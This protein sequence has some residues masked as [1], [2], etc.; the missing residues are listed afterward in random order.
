MKKILIFWIVLLLVV[1]SG[2]TRRDSDLYITFEDL[3]LLNIGETFELSRVSIDEHE[4]VSSNLDVI[5]VEDFIATAVGKGIAHLTAS[6]ND[7]SHHMTLVVDEWIALFNIIGKRN[8]VLNETITYTTQLLPERINQA[9]TWSTTDPL[10]LEID[11]AGNATAVGY[12]L[13]T[14]IAIAEFDQ[15]TIAKATIIVQEDYQEYTLEEENTL[16][17]REETIEI[18]LTSLHNMFAPLVNT[19]KQSVVGISHYQNN[20]GSLSLKS[21]GSG[22]IYKR[23]PIFIEIEDESIF[24]TYEYYVITNRHF[25]KDADVLK[26]YHGLNVPEIT[27]T[28]IEYDD[29]VDLAVLRFE[30]KLYFPIASFGDSDTIQ[31]GEFIITI[32]HA[33]GYQ[34]FQSA[35]LGIISY[36][37]RYLSDDTDGDGRNDWDA[38]YIQHDAPINEGNSGGPVINLKGEVIGINTLKISSVLVE[39]LGFAIPSNLVLEIAELLEQGIKPQ[40]AILGVLVIDVRAVLANQ[41]AFPDYIIP[42]GVTFGFYV[43]E[44]DDT[45]IAYSAGV[46]P[47]DIIVRY[48]QIDMRYSYMLRAEIGKFLIGS[49]DIV[50]MEVIRNGELITLLVTY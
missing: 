4:W 2:C 22:V 41:F 33:M 29:K 1:L 30:S 6:V 50:E 14:I 48:N 23:T 19:T 17:I 43:T 21:V 44:V 35:T 27:A 11:N 31:T 32:G 16:N 9:V 40:R 5:V 13:A 26:I 8:L 3:P 45:G 36:P 39:N 24:K 34:Y 49:G 15:K 28:L 18:N 12:G 7:R 37:A 47:H 46:L 38:L 10:V 20:A 42:P 25:I